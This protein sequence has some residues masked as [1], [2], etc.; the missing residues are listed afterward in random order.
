MLNR[1]ANVIFWWCALLS[2]LFIFGALFGQDIVASL[3]G[4]VVI[5]ALGWVIRYVLTG[6]KGMFS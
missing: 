5:F 6:K 1:L 4:A 2:V 3:F